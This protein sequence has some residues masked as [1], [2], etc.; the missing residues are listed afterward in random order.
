M[1]KPIIL[2][3]TLTTVGLGLYVACRVLT[4][5]APDLIFNIGQSWFHTL[6]MESMKAAT[7][8]GLGTFLLGAVTFGALVWVTTYATA[9]LYNQW[10]K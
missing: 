9:A 5:I 2:A 3:N 8:F 4:L 10:S 6:N 7:V 1:V